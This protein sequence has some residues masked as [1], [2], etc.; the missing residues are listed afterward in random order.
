MNFLGQAENITTKF[1]D[2]ELDDPIDYRVNIRFNCGVF[3]LGKNMNFNDIH[4][5]L[6]NA[7]DALIDA[8][9]MDS[10]DNHIAH[11]DSKLAKE[12]FY[13]NH[14]VTAISEALDQGKLSIMYKQIVNLTGNKVLGFYLE[15]SMDT[16][17]IS[18]VE[19]DNVIKRKG[20]V[21]NIEKYMLRMSYQ[22]MRL[23]N[24]ETKAYPNLFIPVSKET[25]GDK[26]LESLAT[27]EKFYKINPKYITL[28]T[29]SIH[30]TPL[31]ALR[32]S[33]YHLASKDI[34]DV[35]RGLC[36]YLIYDYHG[37]NLESIPEILELCEKHNVTV[38]LS[39]MDNASDIDLARENGYQYIF[40]NYYNKR[41][42]IKDLL[43]GVKRRKN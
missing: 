23:F 5:I 15:I 39:N 6:E 14:L 25:L 2:K 19:M 18:P 26:Y 36:D 21:S 9:N 40:G 4:E 3:R 30:N 38:I 7:S 13:Q 43:Q 16:L 22:E 20:L 1:R 10:K 8:S 33:N 12:R 28:V 29:D 34:F 42:R 41:F 37:V 24:N 35:Y 11:Y 27:N 31:E 17:E 32:G